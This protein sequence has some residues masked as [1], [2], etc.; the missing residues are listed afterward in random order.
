[1]KH[2]IAA[3][4]MSLSIPVFAADQAK[5]KALDSY[6]EIQEALA[7]DSLD[8]AKKLGSSLARESNS[9]SVKKSAQGIAAAKSIEAARESF[10]LLSAT[11]S[12]Q[13][14][15]E[16]PQGYEVIECPMAKAKWVQK[17][18]EIQNPYYGK[19]MLSCGERIQ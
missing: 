12:E 15:K 3:V 17:R 13:V 10:K 4:A 14:Q 16:K 9:E 19:E 2:L 18:G 5:P 1:M 8:K 11:F 6:I 7:K